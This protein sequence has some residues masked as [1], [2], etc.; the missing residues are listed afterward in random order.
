MHN[1]NVVP[2]PTDATHGH[3]INAQTLECVLNEFES[4]TPPPV[5]V[6]NSPCNPTG[7]VYTDEEL[8]Q[9]VGVCRAHHVLLLFDGIY[10]PF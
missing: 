6:L 9:I 10:T 8:Q 2:L 1:H 7:G 3:K 5:L 4:S